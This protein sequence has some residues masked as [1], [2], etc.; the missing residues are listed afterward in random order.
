MTVFPDIPIN[1]LLTWKDSIGNPAWTLWALAWDPRPVCASAQNPI[2]KNSGKTAG[3]FCAA[4]FDGLVN[5]CDADGGGEVTNGGVIWVDCAIYSLQSFQGT[6][7]TSEDR[8]TGATVY[9]GVDQGDS[10][11]AP[12]EPGPAAWDIAIGGREIGES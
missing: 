3:R 9:K 11:P 5:G 4:Q 10:K 6:V 8:D 2:I 7:T 12:P 1:F